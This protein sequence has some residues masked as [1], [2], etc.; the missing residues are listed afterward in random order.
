[1][2]QKFINFLIDNDLYVKFNKGVATKGVLDWLQNTPQFMWFH[3]LEL[4]LDDKY[5]KKVIQ[6][7]KEDWEKI[8]TGKTDR[9]VAWIIGLVAAIMVLVLLGAC[10]RE[11]SSIFKTIPAR[12]YDFSAMRGK[13]IYSIDYA[14]LK[15]NSSKS[16]IIINFTDSTRIKMEATYNGMDVYKK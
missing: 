7:L 15:G 12:D 10:N 3:N 14:E 9:N 2:E 16:I 8:E 5:D 13:T 1:M 6:E 11:K 4:L